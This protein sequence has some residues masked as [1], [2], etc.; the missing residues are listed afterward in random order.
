MLPGA[1][2]R[3]AADPRIA[4][5]RFTSK[6]IAP[7]QQIEIASIPKLAYGQNLRANSSVVLPLLFYLQVILVFPSPC[8]CL[9]IMGFGFSV[10]NF[11]NLALLAIGPYSLRNAIKGSTFVTRRAGT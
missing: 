4:A 6:K 11:A 10:A 7:K 3:K 2:T 1:M 9:S 5:G 8:L